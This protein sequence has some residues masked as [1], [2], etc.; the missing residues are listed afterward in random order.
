[1]NVTDFLEKHFRHFNA[2]EL[3]AAARSYRDFVSGPDGG[4]MMV[5][6]AGAMSTGELGI[7]LAEMIREGKVHAITCTAA[8]L[9]EDIFNLVANGE[10][11]IVEDWRALSAA[12]EIRLRD[13]GFNRVTYTC[14]P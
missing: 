7:S 1:M 12:D 13:A 5:T 10:Y 8:N 9:E 4:R 2:R 11:R 6:L 3:L 14:I